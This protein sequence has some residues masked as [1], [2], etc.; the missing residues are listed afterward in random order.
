MKPGSSVVVRKMFVT[1]EPI[2]EGELFNSYHHPPPRKEE[3]M[4]FGGG[5]CMML[6]QR[7]VTAMLSDATV[8]DKRQTGSVLRRNAAPLCRSQLMLG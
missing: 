5:F 2:V 3:A 1:P 4:R 8:L 6:A 7:P